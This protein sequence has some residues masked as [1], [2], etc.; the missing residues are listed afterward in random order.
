MGG[1]DITGIYMLCSFKTV[2]QLVYYWEFLMI[3]RNKLFMSCA[4]RGHV[5]T[6]LHVYTHGVHD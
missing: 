6:K 2:F 1:V 5:I 3:P 4:C